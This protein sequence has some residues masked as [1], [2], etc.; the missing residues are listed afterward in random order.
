MW[1]HSPQQ[2]HYTPQFDCLEVRGFPVI[3]ILL[4]LLSSRT[5]F[6]EDTQQQLCL[7]LNMYIQIKNSQT[8]SFQAIERYIEQSQMSQRAESIE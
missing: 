2:T 4:G 7:Q 6:R 3:H 5:R 8:D 1:K